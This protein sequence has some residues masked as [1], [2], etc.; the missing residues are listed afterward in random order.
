MSCIWLFS[1]HFVDAKQLLPRVVDCWVGSELTGAGVRMS[2]HAPLWLAL[3]KADAA[4]ASA[5]AAGA[6]S[7]SS[8]SSSSAASSSSS[9]AS[10]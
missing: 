7:A 5:S 1:D 2:D 10:S 9:S 4:P 8:S 6:A 3:R